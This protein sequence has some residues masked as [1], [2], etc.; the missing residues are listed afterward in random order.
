MTDA[1]PS[2]TEHDETPD[3]E[4]DGAP[5]V[6]LG[7]ASSWDSLILIGLF[8]LG[9]NLGDRIQGEGAGLKWAIAAVSAFG[10]Y[11][12]IKRYRRGLPI[13]KFL[14]IILVYLIV[15]GTIGIVFDSADVYFGIG[16]GTKVLVGLVL[17]GSVLIGR[18]LMATLVPYVLPFKS[19]TKAH[20]TW[21]STMS[22][23]TIVAAAFQLLTAV[24]DVWLL[25]RSSASGYVVIRSAVGMV[26]GFTVFFGAFFYARRRLDTIPGF[27]GL[28]EMLERLATDWGKPADETP[29]AGRA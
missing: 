24:W 5:V 3:P 25:Q 13:G 23:L 6:S 15:R 9:E 10:V 2:D 1:Q 26:S 22:H 29:E 8:L 18:P 19:R 28:M 14:P 7:G 21:L 11:S 27:E 16:I 4:D 17:A 12:I 20:P